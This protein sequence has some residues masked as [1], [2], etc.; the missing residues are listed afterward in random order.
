MD[1]LSLSALS[2][3]GV[4]LLQ[5]FE[6]MSF[7]T[8]FFLGLPT[9]NQATKGDLSEADF[10]GPKFTLSNIGMIG[11]ITHLQRLYGSTTMRCIHSIYRRHCHFPADAPPIEVCSHGQNSASVTRCQQ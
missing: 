3:C 4:L 2:C 9:Q 10:A 11:Y 5:A 7:F 8:H 6:N 1:S